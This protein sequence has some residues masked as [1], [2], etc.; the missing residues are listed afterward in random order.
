M[1]HA[2]CLFLSVLVSVLCAE[3]TEPAGR[4]NLAVNDSATSKP[5][6]CTVILVDSKGK[7]VV[8]NE[9]FRDGIRCD[10]RLA[11]SLPAG[12]FRL[13]VTRGFE[14]RMVERE[15]EV[16][17][18]GNVDVSVDL[19]RVVDLRCKGWYGGDSHVHMLH[20]EKTLPVDFDYIG[21]TAR[22]E[23]LQYLSIAQ[24]WSIDDPTPEKLEA[25]FQKRST[26]ECVV[27]WNLEAPKNYYR[28]DAGR[29]LG[30]CW[31]VG[32]RG[33]TD[34]G[35]DVIRLLM[36]A[37]AHDY[38][39]EKPP[40]ANF[41]SHAMIHAQGGTAF[42][43]HPARWWTG[44]WGGQGGYPKQEKMRVS[45][46]AVE[47]PLDTLIGP[48]YD[49]IDLMTS[50]G[51]YEANV[52][53]FKLWCLLLN[54][55]YRLAGTA[56]SDSCFDRPGGAVPGSVRT[57][58]QVEGEFSLTKVAQAMARGRNFA[59]SGPLLL[60]S[61]DGQP[62]GSSFTADG[63]DKQLRIE[64]WA[65]GT[66]VKGLSLVEILKNGV[67]V[68]TN[69]FS[70]GVSHVVTNLVLS[71]D[72]PAWYCV[73]VCGN[74]QR[75]QRAISGAFF[76]ES[77]DRRPPDPVR[78][79]V[80]VKIVDAATGRALAGKITEVSVCSTQT[81]E[82]K[83]HAVA[84]EESVLDVPATCRLRAEAPGYQPVTL[85]PFLDNPELRDFITALSADD[86]LKWETYE[87]IQTL[88][89]DVSLGFGVRGE[90]VW[91]FDG[92]KYP[93]RPSREDSFLGIHFD[94]HAGPDCK[95]IGMNTTMAMVENIINLVHPDYLQIDC[96][97]H[98]GFSSYPTKVGNQAPGF[99]R[100]PLKI[101][102]QVTAEKG[103]ALYMHYS[104]IWDSEAIIKHPD[105]AAI[106]SDG[107]TNA[108]ATS[109]FG[110]Y[111]DKLL[112]PQLRELAG[113]YGVDGAWIDGECWAS[114][115]DYGEAALKAFRA[116]TGL[117]DVPRK[118][119][120]AN[121]FEFLQFH[122][123]A[124]R[125]YLRHYIAEVKKTNPEFQ[126][127]SNWA[128][129]DHMAEPVSAPL[130][131]LS[132]DYSPDNSV[133]SA[134][135]SA[136]YLV[137]QGMQWDLM[138]WSFSRKK[139]KDGKVMQKSA[140]QLE[141][142]AAVVVALG[143]GFQAYF[144]QKRD[145]SIYDEQMPVMA[146]VAKFCRARQALCHHAEPVPQVALLLSTAGHYRR[147]NG[148]FNR[149]LDR[150]NGVLQALLESQH[151][152]EVVGEHQVA[153]RLAAYPLIVV[154]EW[155]CLEPTFRN[156]LTDYVK[157]GGSLL[158]IGPKSAT[159]FQAELGVTFEGE[160]GSK[161][162]M[163]SYKGETVQTKGFAQRLKPGEGV[164]PLGTLQE[165]SNSV[166]QPAAVIA[167]LGKGR[168]AATCVDVGQGYAATRSAVM[169]GLINDLACRLFP[170]PMVE[171]TGSHDIDV[172]LTRKQGKLL[173]NLVNTSGPHQSEPIQETVQPVG[174]LS[175]TI[176]RADKPAGIT[177]EPGGQKMHFEYRDGEIK[178][179]VPQVEIHSVIVVE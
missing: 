85:S 56:S 157:A 8:E 65:S 136:R 54:H 123:E 69:A 122:R 160:P 1:K 126:I 92:S 27:T 76:F 10:G 159:L 37:S 6:P 33:R 3:G 12:K 29:C 162:Q 121:W 129:T 135:L 158:L 83:S 68:Q 152:V 14:T 63:H 109:P 127:C 58:T 16:P 11:K 172:C 38:E 57:Y 139:G 2:L 100:D 40:F 141:R 35:A 21:L 173:V 176:R 146:E 36:Q 155:E 25:E 34:D 19:E 32:V 102:R 39:S 140:P 175:V 96:K 179:T 132:G 151:S 45:N 148:L 94:F 7:T 31:T 124:F 115:P 64:A 91:K 105:W 50:A 161:P 70:P 165:S 143:G 111:A 87:R 174:P 142:E 116:A 171:V 144:K 138:A 67:P 20:G 163:L 112:I 154:P 98:R 82:G 128:Y 168:I 59:T 137:R 166:T 41:E 113:V 60:V 18:G 5:V 106:N 52:R 119:T 42:Y 130:D 145:G 131:F 46:L 150:V 120:D 108:N 147:I 43:S 97:G 15:V 61:I 167:G 149:E 88:L 114:V 66:D 24:A 71:D 104:G 170:K 22:A 13:R 78:A 169:R 164:E 47:L 4:L 93:A 72:K 79:R 74:D 17:A 107:K 80:R 26:P 28:G 30:H 48:T 84:A 118:A 134:R 62:P 95:E 23:D 86:L 177:L 103:V 9:S 55:D 53:A 51:E 178:L 44:A 89:G 153:G 77:K 110:P 156:D 90:D 81:R 125:V 117:Q 99:V 133:N 49:G 75:R 101:W 73:R